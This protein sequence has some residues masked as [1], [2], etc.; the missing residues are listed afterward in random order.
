MTCEASR[1]GAVAGL[2][3][4]PRLA[5]SACRRVRRGAMARAIRC[6]PIAIPIED[7]AVQRPTYGPDTGKPFFLGGYA[8]ANYG[9]L[10]PRAC[11]AR[12]SR[13]GACRR[14]SRRFRLSRVPGIP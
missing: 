10:F 3:G 6:S 12:M 14:R 7:Y 1:F 13:A 11:D 2:G 8:G 5:S 4:D 9:P